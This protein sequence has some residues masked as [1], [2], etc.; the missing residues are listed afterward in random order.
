MSN[1]WQK[2]L[3]PIVVMAPMANVSD[4][5]FRSMFAKYGK[6]DVIW[7]EFV[8]ADGLCSPGKKILLRDLEFSPKERPIVAQL[9][10]GHADKMFE[11]AKLV[12]SLGF[13]GLDINMGCPDRAVE[14]QGA[15]AAHIKDMENSIKVLH[16]ARLGAPTLPVSVKTRIGY[17]KNEI[18]TWIRKLLEQKLPALTVHLRTRKEMSDVP[19]HWELMP[20]IVEL[21]NEISPE[22][23]IIGNGDVFSMKD[24]HEK[25]RVSGCDGVMIGRG[26]FGNPWFFSGRLVSEISPQERLEVMLEH[27]R[28]FDKLLGD[29]KNFAIMKKHF[30]AYVSGWDGA[31]ELRVKL[32]E[33]D[34]L[35]AVEKVICG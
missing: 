16:T 29:V 3:K 11:A 14:K 6:P 10:T 27:A 19:A 24:A 12:E 1:F 8:S 25:I 26:I 30:K 35:R 34:D 5:A 20:R 17:N 7:T 4:V 23:I 22:T 13:D 2:L 33:C 28:V 18:E 32:M 9:F 15:G 31:K 21:R